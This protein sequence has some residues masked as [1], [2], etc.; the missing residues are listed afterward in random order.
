MAKRKATLDLRDIRNA[1]DKDITADEEEL[2]KREEVFSVKYTDP[3]GKV[4]SANVVSRI[5][6][7]EE[8][9]KVDRTAAIMAGCPWGQ[10][11]P[12]A[13]ARF[14]A[15]S[16]VAIQLREPPSW[17]EKWCVEDNALL[18]TL[19]AKLQEHESFFFRGDSEESPE[20]Q[21][22]GRVEIS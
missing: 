10:L 6:T 19:F 17:L 22:F 13:Q 8:R 18:F 2:V 1:S 9:N 3:S 15:M 11:P 7:G 14:L 5:L 12:G 20:A 4:H 16:Q 21:G